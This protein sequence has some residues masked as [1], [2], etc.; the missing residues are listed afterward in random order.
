[1]TGCWADDR[2]SGILLARACL[3]EKGGVIR[4]KMNSIPHD[5]APMALI[6]SETKPFG[7]TAI[8]SIEK[9]LLES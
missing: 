5:F 1:V 8:F 9:I 4:R 6:S 7:C 3:R 2:Y